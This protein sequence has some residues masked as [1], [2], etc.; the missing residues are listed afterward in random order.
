LEVIVVDDGSSDA[1]SAIVEEFMRKDPRVQLVRQN[2]A[3]VGAA[4]NAGIRRAHGKYIAPLDADDLWCPNKLEKQVA[5]IE[6]CGSETG[7]VYCW[8]TLVDKNGD[9]LLFSDPHPYE[10]RLRQALLLRNVVGNASAPLIRATAF[11]KLGFYLTRA[12]QGGGEGAK[13]GISASGLPS[14]LA[15]ASFQ[16]I[17]WHIGK[18]I[19]E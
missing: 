6:Q 7:M 3:G 4:R 8:S 10:G 18:P 15:S 2:N 16:S 17:W 9:F 5:R 1:T 12:E 19:P 11:E 14:L 13:I